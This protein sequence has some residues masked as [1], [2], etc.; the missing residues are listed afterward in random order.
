MYK[1][2]LDI[3]RSASAKRKE[4]LNNI[5]NKLENLSKKLDS[6]NRYEVQEE[7]EDIITFIKV[8]NG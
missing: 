6:L 4:V 3:A 7:I 8:N 5:A 1:T 2:E